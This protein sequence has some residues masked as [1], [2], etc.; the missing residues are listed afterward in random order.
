MEDNS[1][2][3][4]NVFITQRKV[5][6]NVSILAEICLSIHLLVSLA[7]ISTAA[8]LTDADEKSLTR[9]FQTPH[10]VDVVVQMNYLPAWNNCRAT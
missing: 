7:Q 8:L 1:G 4:L 10:G 9:C 6:S 5:S 2:L 3:W